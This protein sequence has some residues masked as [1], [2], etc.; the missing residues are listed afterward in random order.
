MSIHEEIEVFLASHADEGYRAFQAKLIPNI[1]AA[2]IVG[3]RTPD[4]RKFAKGLARRGDAGEFLA[5]LPHGTFEENQLH[6]FVIAR[7]RDFDRLVGAIENFL[8]F[9]DNW[10]TCDQLSCRGLAADPTAALAK[11]RAWL[12]SDHEYTVRFAIG[13]LMQLFLEERFRPE[14]FGWVVGIS[15]PEYYVNMMRAWY[16]AEALAKQPEAA[17]RV[18]AVGALDEWTHNKAIQ[19]AVESRRIASEQKEHLRALRRRLS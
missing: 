10:A 16:F 15:R 7:E 3:V 1:D 13:V 17:E 14:Y 8:P 2:T 4:L 18:I 5:A 9:V 19:K 11:A 12:E 6:S